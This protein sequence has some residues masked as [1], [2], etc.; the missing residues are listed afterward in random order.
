MND[1]FD[2]KLFLLRIIRKYAVLILGTAIGALL[3]GGGYL[4]IKLVFVKPSYQ[5]R[6]VVHENLHYND[7]LGQFTYINGYTWNEFVGTDVIAGMAASE[8]GGGWTKERIAPMLSAELQSDTRVVYFYVTGKSQGEVQTVADAVIPAILKVGEALPEIEDM[9][10]MDLSSQPYVVNRIPYAGN[11][12]ILGTILGFVLAFFILT[13]Y[14]I[15][16][17]SVYIPGLFE[18][19]YGIPMA[20]FE[21]EAPSDALVIS[22]KLPDLSKVTEGS[23]PD[24]Y[25][26]SGA[27][28]GT[29]VDKV[30]FDL[31]QKNALPKQ[32][33]LLKPVKWLIRGYYAGTAFPNPFLKD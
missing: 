3:V 22:R 33:Y 2:L 16:D 28:N 25:I 9:L 20:V 4:V 18:R 5:V 23:N 29:L 30:L 26:V 14:V 19:K 15:A 13:L 17:D 24:I 31:K 10:I 1:R 8:L 6:A 32:A 21:G 12:F 11:A 7:E 27:Y